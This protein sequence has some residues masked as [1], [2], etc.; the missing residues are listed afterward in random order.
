MIMLRPFDLATLRL[1]NRPGR[2][3]HTAHHVLE[4]LEL[5]ETGMTRGV[6]VPGYIRPNFGMYDPALISAIVAHDCVYK[7][8]AP[9]GQNET[10]SV[11]AWRDMVR[12]SPQ[13][14][15]AE[16]DTAVE[17]IIMA[18]VDHI[19]P[20]P[21]SETSIIVHD[22]IKH[23]IDLDMSVLAA[24]PAEFEQNTENVRLE[25]NYGL[26]LGIAWMDFKRARNV[27]FQSVLDQ[28]SIF[29][30]PQFHVALEEK[31]RHNLRTAIAG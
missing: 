17:K 16:W 14:V 23:M 31:A 12:A 30:T 1:Y 11:Q 22:A 21:S 13:G 10:A 2:F 6:H 7:P 26:T 9:K 8:G 18:T 29:F 3:Y 15:A 28:P 20:A 24:D 19:P 5:H 27:F 4:L 25:A